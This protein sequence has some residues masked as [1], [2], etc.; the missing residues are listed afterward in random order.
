MY[1]PVRFTFAGF[2]EQPGSW[3]LSDCHSDMK[4][5]Q[6]GPCWT[7]EPNPAQHCQPYNT[8][9]PAPDTTDT[10][11]DLG[12]AFV[13]RAV[14]FPGTPVSCPN[15]SADRRRTPPWTRGKGLFQDLGGRY[16]GM[17]ERWGG[18]RDD[19]EFSGASQSRRRY[20]EIV[21]MDHPV[22]HFIPRPV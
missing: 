19:G 22:A 2:L 7:G 14:S 5:K 9:A 12:V 16:Q 8:I 18:G 4:C 15:R 6:K 1:N 3:C 11:P 20:K 17:V 10:N 21:A 13:D